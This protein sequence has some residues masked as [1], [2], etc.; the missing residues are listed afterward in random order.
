MKKRTM[1]KRIDVIVFT[2]LAVLFAAL[3]V[4]TGLLV[5][6][7]NRNTSEG[8]KNIPFDLDRITLNSSSV[9]PDD[10]DMLLLPEFIGIKL[11]E[12]QRGVTGSVDVIADAYRTFAPAIASTLREEYCKEGDEIRWNN[13]SN[14]ENYVYVRFHSQLPDMVIA[15]FADITAGEI[16]TRNKLSS[17]VYEMFIIPEDS[18]GTGET[19]AVKSLS[20]DVFIYRNSGN[21]DHVSTAQ[22]SKLLQVYSSQFKKFEFANKL[23]YSVT[24]TDPV[25]VESISTRNIFMTNNVAS[26]TYGNTVKTIMRVFGVNPDKLLN[27]H[28]GD[29]GTASYTD[30]SGVFYHYESAFEYKAT[31]DGGVDI[32]EIIGYSDKNGLMEYLSAAL[33]IFDE[34]GRI[35]QNYVGAE[36]DVYLSSVTSDGSTVELEFAYAYDN[37]RIAEIEPAFT[38]TFKDGKLM[39]ARVY[40]LAVRNVSSRSAPR[41]EWWFYDYLESDSREPLN[42][43]LVYRS[44]FVSDKVTA[45]WSATVKNTPGEGYRY[46]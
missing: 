4:I 19:I 6:L 27:T 11:G 26:M 10:F 30:R 28:T 22:L 39:G 23:S 17:Y 33:A 18:T 14:A 42:V 37:I 20:G 24:S 31:E 8:N 35:N 21:E 40:T 15:M 13:I 5:D 29:D 43:G 16:E 45:E 34:V 9:L 44:D 41:A 7:F 46:R 38:A 12:E 32:D 36:A 2:L 1:Q 3:V 25:F